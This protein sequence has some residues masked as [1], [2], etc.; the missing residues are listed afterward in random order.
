MVALGFK[1]AALRGEP[2]AR[3][4]GALLVLERCEDSCGGFLTRWR[5]GKAARHGEHSASDAQNLKLVGVRSSG[6]VGDGGG[7][8]HDC[9][10]RQRRA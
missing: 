6:S 9:E 1:R 4:G 3:F 8:K 5:A 10:R 7:L 2:L